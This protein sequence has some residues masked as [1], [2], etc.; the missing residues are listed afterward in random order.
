M[1]LSKRDSLC[2]KFINLFDYIS[3]EITKLH[4]CYSHYSIS[5]NCMNFSSKFERA[6]ISIHFSN[7]I[8]V[9]KIKK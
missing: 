6:D 3:V 7:F 1:K 8:K 5:I 9:A 2:T 4:S